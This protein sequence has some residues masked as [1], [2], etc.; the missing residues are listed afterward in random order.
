MGEWAQAW[1]GLLE[2]PS[3]DARRA[4]RRGEQGAALHRAGRVGPLRVQSGFAV[5]Q[6]QGSRATPYAVELEVPLLDDDEWEIVSEVLAS[7]HRYGAALLAGHPPEGLIDLLATRGLALLPDADEV[8][9]LCPCSSPSPCAHIIATWE[10]V[11]AA[12]EDDPFQLFQLRGRGRERLL[13]EVTAARRRSLPADDHEIAVGELDATRWS[14]APRSLAELARTWPG[15]RRV[16]AAP[17]LVLLGDPPGWPDG[18]DPPTEVFG[19]LVRRAVER[20]G[21]RIDGDI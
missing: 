13:A 14:D 19:P 17:V 1:G 5:A 20:L 18:A 11:G 7:E 15:D 21:S 9:V 16:D 8:D 12:F 4:D 3:A 6:V 2:R 10:A